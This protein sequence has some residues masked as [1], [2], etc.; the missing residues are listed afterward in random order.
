MALDG[1][2]DQAG[3]AREDWLF[4]AI[5][6][7][8]GDYTFADLTAS[9]PGHSATF[10]VFA[11]SLKIDGI[12]I[13]V[14][15][16]TEQ[17]IADTLGCLLLTPR[18]ADL[19]W[20]Q[21]SAKLAPHPRL[22]TSA[23]SAMIAHSAQ[24]DADLAALGYSG[25]I[26]CTVGKHWCIDNDLN[27]HPGRAENYGWHFEGVLSGIPAENTASKDANGRYM[28]IIQGRGWA[29]DMHHVDYSQVCVLVSRKCTVDG[30]DA[31]LMDVLRD[32][33]LAPLASHQ[34]V[35]HVLRQP[36]VPEVPCANFIPPITIVGDPGNGTPSV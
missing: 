12:R 23:T 35:M 29:H 7:G 24:I 11:D 25:G 19:M 32:P 10:K 4:Q 21:K 33:T 17:K 28:Q 26:V 30:I 18:L 14:S 22:I 1:I 6:A 3:Q 5:C 27:S 31:D 16:E 9:I 8:R 20:I 2:P 34:G 13:N 36:G 15:A